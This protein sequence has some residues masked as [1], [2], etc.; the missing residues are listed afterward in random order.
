[1]NRPHTGQEGRAWFGLVDVLALIIFAILGAGSHDRGLS[2]TTIALI[3]WPFLVGAAAG[4]ALVRWRSGRWPL[5]LGPGITVWLSTI[6]I[7]MLL[8]AITTLD[9]PQLSFV[10]VA[11]GATALLML[12]WRVL[13][14]AVLTRAG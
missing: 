5:E 4:W 8:R 3:V 12:G 14:Q 1:M 10:L 2:P 13:Y 11:T 7:G 9:L 6:V